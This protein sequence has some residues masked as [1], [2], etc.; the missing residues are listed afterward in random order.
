M[1]LEL[2]LIAVND[3]KTMKRLHLIGRKNHGK[4]RLIVDLVEE[5]TSRG[6]RVGT[7]KHTHHRHELDTPGKDSYQHRTA[8]AAVV[9]I[10]S[11]S[12]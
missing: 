7:I 5:L 3:L 8:G 10:L 9:G 11:R 2:V 12:M 4:T 6:L 1:T